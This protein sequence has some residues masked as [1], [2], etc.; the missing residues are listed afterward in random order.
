LV[1]GLG[2][3]LATCEH[4]EVPTIQNSLQPMLTAYAE[5]QMTAADWIS[6]PNSIVGVE[7]AQTKID[8]APQ[9]AAT[10]YKEN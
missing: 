2:L 5:M 6:D 4:K 10:P 7:Q 8:P 9:R 1:L 3:Y